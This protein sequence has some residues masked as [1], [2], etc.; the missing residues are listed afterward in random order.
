LARPVWVDDEHFD[1]ANHVDAVALPAPHDEAALV[2]LAED[3]FMEPL[4]RDRPLWHLRFVTGLSEDRVALIQRSHHAM[5]DGVSGVDVSLVLLDTER[6]VADSRAKRWVRRPV[7]TPE[8][9][10]ASAIL[11]RVATPVGVAASVAASMARPVSLVRNMAKTA[12]ALGELRHDG[13]LA[14]HTSLNRQIGDRRRLAFIRERLEPVHA[15]GVAAGAKVND[16]VL[17]AVAGGVRDLFLVR[18]D[19]LPADLRLKVLIPVSVR[20]GEESMALGNRVGGMFAPLPVGIGDPHERLRI[21]AE[22]TKALK[23]SEEAS[24]ADQLLRFANLL[25]SSLVR[26]IQHGVN[27]QPFVNM[28]V[29]NIPGPSF[30]LYAM[31]AKMLEAFPVVPLAGNMPLEVAVLSYHGQLNLCVT[32]DET[33]CPDADVFVR[34]VERSFAALGA[35]WAPALAS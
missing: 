5:V 33:G 8:Q 14:P 23:H 30:P 11:D 15:V 7:P 26:L 9:L 35:Q 27:H 1:V 17:A 3:V 13:F 16:V 2:R 12:G 20:G 24:T 31:G 10:V 28:V 21:I 19:S 18:G 32:S 4:P 25:P 22:T 34:G 29:T 6:D